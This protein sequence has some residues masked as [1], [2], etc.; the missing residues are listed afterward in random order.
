MFFSTRLIQPHRYDCNRS[1]KERKMRFTSFRVIALLALS[2]LNPLLCHAQ[3]TTEQKLLIVCRAL[4]WSFQE[5]RL[6][7]PKPLKNV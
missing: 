1:D 4:C 5:E 3:L 7:S 6:F 2:C